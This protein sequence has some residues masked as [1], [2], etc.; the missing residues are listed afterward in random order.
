M[1][2]Q[3]RTPRL[4]LR[5]PV[6]SELHT[7]GSRP[8]SGGTM[9]LSSRSLSQESGTKPPIYRGMTPLS[10]HLAESRGHLNARVTRLERQVRFLWCGLVLTLAT[11]VYFCL[12][13]QVHADPDV[14]VGLAGQG[15]LT[16]SQQ[17]PK[18]VDATYGAH[19][20]SDRQT[21]TWRRENL[22]GPA[23]RGERPQ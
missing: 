18:G 12:E 5:G 3:P 4:S 14:R 22:R 23:K 21:R 9:I 15:E 7:T 1:R 20:T 19:S 13:Y 11:L 6:R 10:R 8:H 2:P 17:E 16:N